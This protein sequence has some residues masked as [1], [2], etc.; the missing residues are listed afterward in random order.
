MDTEV[1]ARTSIKSF[2]SGCTTNKYASPFSPGFEK[3]LDKI[4]PINGFTDP[5][6]QSFNPKLDS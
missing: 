1:K 4:S 3:I 2:I 5:S 6:K